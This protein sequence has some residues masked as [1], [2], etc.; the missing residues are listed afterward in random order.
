MKFFIETKG[1][2]DIVDITY[3]VRD[4]IKESRAAD[5]ICLISCPGS[6]C[7][8]TT[9]EFEVGAI[10]D[11]KRILDKLV[12]PDKN[13]EHNKA[14][15]DGNGHAHVRSALVKPSLVLPVEGGAPVLGRW[16]NVIFLDFDSQP[17][18]REISVKVVK[19]S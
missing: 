14:W 10:K 7:G 19:A 6:T 8:I 17:R 16:Q 11:L 5:G 3:Q 2:C 13:Y 1:N 9:M 4:I 18:R 15:G 12:P